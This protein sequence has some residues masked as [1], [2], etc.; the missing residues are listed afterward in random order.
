M[1][2]VALAKR[3]P[4]LL[5]SILIKSTGAIGE[6]LVAEKLASLGY[7]VEPTNNNARQRDLLVI[8]SNGNRF[9]VEVKADRSKRPT[10]FV[11]TRPDLSCSDF[12]VFVS[13][14]RDPTDFPS[15]AQ[16]EMFVLTTQ[17]AQK[18]WDKSEWN[19]KHPDKGDIRRWQIPDQSRDAWE[20]LP[21]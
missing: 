2:I 4:K 5:E 14:P 16:I 19:Q 21:K 12:W 10:W 3:H 18:L 17:E 6:V 20:K 9:C 7:A 13:A 1:D 11:R 15:P 8:S